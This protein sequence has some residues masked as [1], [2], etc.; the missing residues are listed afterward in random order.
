MASCPTSAISATTI[1][2]AA[3]LPVAGNGPALGSSTPMTTPGRKNIASATVVISLPSRATSARVSSQALDKDSF[4][5]PASP[6]LSSSYVRRSRPLHSL[7][8]A[9]VGRAIWP[10]VDRVADIEWR[11]SDGLTPYEQALQAMGARAA[12]IRAG[13][14]E[15][16]VWLL[17]HPPLFTAGTS[18]AQE[19]LLNPLHFPVH[20]AGRGGRY[21]YHGPG[22][23]V[24][25]LIL[26]LEKRGRDVRWLV[27]ALAGWGYAALDDL[28]VE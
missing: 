25:Y 6:E 2:I 10:A 22:Q 12:A 14:A 20:E 3:S 8:R 18:A 24:G 9:T 27:H 28:G 17:E 11:V 13:A 16:L 1:E 23:R 26:D 21:T 5:T 4:V 15:E 19:E 7:W